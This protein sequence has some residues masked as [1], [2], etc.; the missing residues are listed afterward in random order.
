MCLAHIFVR[1]LMLYVHKNTQ[2]FYFTRLTSTSHVPRVRHGHF[3]DQMH[4]YVDRIIITGCFGVQA[5][6]PCEGGAIMEGPT[7]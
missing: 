5:K 3:F 1:M 7:H 6:A 4:T 2:H